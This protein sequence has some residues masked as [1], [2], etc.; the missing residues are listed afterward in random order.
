MRG[1]PKLATTVRRL[2][3]D[4]AG[5]LFVSMPAE[6]V[7]FNRAGGWCDVKPLRV[8]EQGR[9]FTKIS[10]CPVLFHRGGGAFARFDLAS[11]DKV[12]LLCSDRS[13]E[14]LVARGDVVS[15]DDPRRHSLN[16][17]LVIPGL[18]TMDDPI[19]WAGGGFT[20][21]REDGNLVVTITDQGR[22]RIE[23][24]NTGTELLDLIDRGLAAIQTMMTA[25]AIGPQPPDPATINEVSLVRAELAIIKG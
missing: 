2:I 23:N 15:P 6:V 7:S 11:G 3:E 19:S 24:A 25:T 12:T 14:E 8:D 16:D 13:I 5:Q 4:W 21:G 18:L 1:S 17:A 9:A 10:R 22:I 20:F